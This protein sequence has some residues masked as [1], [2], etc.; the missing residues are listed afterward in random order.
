MI[1][2]GFQ[3]EVSP[4]WMMTNTSTRRSRKSA[5]VTPIKVV[6][7]LPLSSRVL[8][9]PSVR[10]P[11]AYINTRIGGVPKRWCFPSASRTPSLS[12]F[13]RKRKQKHE[14]L[15]CLLQ[16]D[17][18]RS[19]GPLEYEGGTHRTWVS[20]H[21]GVG[22]TLNCPSSCVFPFAAVPMG[23]R[24]STGVSVCVVVDSRWFRTLIRSSPP[25]TS[26][27]QESS[28]TKWVPVVPPISEPS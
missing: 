5:T 19:R 18:D 25:L 13:H 1:W 20:V 27:P 16:L 3:V 23:C 10:G 21:G 11:R 12:A 22:S 15:F 7:C 17:R 6:L 26:T 9:A 2:T 4:Q 8:G 14:V 24:I 28:T